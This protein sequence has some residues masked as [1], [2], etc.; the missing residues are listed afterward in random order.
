MSQ[1]KNLLYQDLARQFALEGKTDIEPTFLRL[2]GR[3][4]HLRFLPNV[5]FRTSR[6][7]MLAGIPIVPRLL[8]Y[9]NVTLFGLEVTPK[10]E[11]GPGLFLPHPVGC[12]IGAWRIGSNV[13][14][15]Q[16]VGLGAIGD[17]H[18]RK[19]MRCEIGSNVILGSGCKIL[20]PYYIGDNAVIGANSVVSKSVEA[21][22]SVFGI[23][24][25]P[26]YAKMLASQNTDFHERKK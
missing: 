13:T 7:A 12:V 24:A 20:G 8:T 10:C 3:L 14:M 1:L 18:F 5:I 6:A 15:Y 21:G 25:K 17:M 4:L 2:L 23:P 22:Q 19:E 16:G 11:I 26:I 9:I